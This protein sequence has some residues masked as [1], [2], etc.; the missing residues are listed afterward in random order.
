MTTQIS[1]TV[2][3]LQNILDVNSTPGLLLGYD[4]Q[5]N[6]EASA[7][8]EVANNE[9]ATST[10]LEHLSY[11]N[12]RTVRLAVASNARTSAKTLAGMVD[13]E[14]DG[15]VVAIAMNPNTDAKTLA[16][17][18]KSDDKWAWGLETYL[19]WAIASHS[20]AGIRTLAKLAKSDD[21]IVR[22]NARANANFKG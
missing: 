13:D 9:N 16:K 15:I 19:H 20:N 12:A 2:Q 5:A 3:E 14:G 4:P 17:L 7:R 10:M 6:Q 22:R 8:E 21:L 11:D 1:T 18:A